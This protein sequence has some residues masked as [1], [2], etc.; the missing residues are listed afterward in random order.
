MGRA[1]PRRARTH[2]THPGDQNANSRA[3]R[4]GTPCF[5]LLHYEKETDP[6]KNARKNLIATAQRD[7]AEPF[8]MFTTKTVEMAAPPQRGGV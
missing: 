5:V 4:A 1:P 8:S 2:L 7:V 6:P 3:R